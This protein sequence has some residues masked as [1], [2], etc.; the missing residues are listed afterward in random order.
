M[1]LILDW[2]VLVA[3]GKNKNKVSV[4]KCYTLLYTDIDYLFYVPTENY[5]NSS[6]TARHVTFKEEFTDKLH[7][8]IHL[9]C[10]QVYQYS[11]RD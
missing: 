6:L 5:S 10:V 4:R 7:V 8:Y 2:N 3:A 9:W 11:E 1:S